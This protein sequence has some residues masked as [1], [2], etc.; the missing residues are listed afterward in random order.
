MKSYRHIL[1][2][3]DFSPYCDRA[4]V[5]A[6]K[7]AKGSGAKLTL[8][9]VV[10]HFA[11]DRSNE[12]IAPEDVDPKVFRERKARTD[13]ETQTGRTDCPE[14]NREVSFSTRAAA[15]EIVRYAGANGVDLIVVASHGHKGI[16]ANLGSTAKAVQHHAPCEVD[17]VPAEGD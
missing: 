17:I 1:C 12:E 5:H 10:D 2:A 14:A 13:L 15:H 16:I 9:H 3:T 11:V 4:C 7:L 8:L 6:A